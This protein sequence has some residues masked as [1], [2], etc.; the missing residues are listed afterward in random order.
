MTIT[1]GSQIEITLNMDLLGNQALNVYQYD[2]DTLPGGVAAVDIANAWWQ[3][4]KAA[5]RALAT[6]TFNTPFQ[7]VRI[8]ELNNPVGD[9]AEYSIPTGER[10]GTRPT[11]TDGVALAPFDAVGVRLV[12]GSRATRP[13]QKRLPFLTEEDQ[14]AGILQ[15]AL[16]ALVVTLMNL[17][18]TSITLGAPAALAVLAPIVTRKDASG[19]VTASQPITGYLINPN[20]TTQNTRKYGRGS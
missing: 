16:T 8:L 14:G 6:A 5:Y 3:H 19:T 11:P 12:V 13:G 20:V 10:A 4:V 7:S 15:P 9:F 18:T 17:L 1:V 2:V